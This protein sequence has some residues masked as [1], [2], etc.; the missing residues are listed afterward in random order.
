MTSPH[1]MR[2]DDR[3]RV[4]PLTL[5]LPR[6]RRHAWGFPVSLVLHAILVMLVA[7]SVHR[8]WSR[9]PVAGPI[10]ITLPPVGGGGGGS[11]EA[12]I[13]PPSAPSP[14]PVR[15][16][17]RERPVV[18]PPVVAPAVVPPPAPPDTEPQVAAAPTADSS[19][20]GGQSGGVGPGAGPGTGGGTGGGT[21][22]GTGPGVGG[23]QGPGGGGQPPEPRQ[24]VIP[25]SDFPKE[26]RGRQIEVTFFVAADGRVEHIRVAPA[27][28]NGGFARKFDESM[29]NYRFRPAR[30]AAG[31]PIAGSTTI[32][33]S[34]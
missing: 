1:E 33:V 28:A 30:S 20:T 31:T 29:R 26:L 23:G 11:R 12:Y 18:A 8:D 19:V 21:G 24:L 14:A 34:F 15:E 3:S 6:S 5:R 25:P 27:I 9:T 32:T 13:T 16:R 7:V 17:P 2:P 22:T 4:R 10:A